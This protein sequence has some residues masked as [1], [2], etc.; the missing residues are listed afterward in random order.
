MG[1]FQNIFKVFVFYRNNFAV[2]EDNNKTLEQTDHLLTSIQSERIPNTKSPTPVEENMLNENTAPQITI[3]VENVEEMDPLHT[4]MHQSSFEQQGIPQMINKKLPFHCNICGKK[5]IRKS[6]LKAHMRSHT[7]ERP[8]ECLVCDYKFKYKHNL[9]THMVLHDDK[10]P[11]NCS[12]CNQKFNKMPFLD[13][14]MRI[15]AQ[16]KQLK[17]NNKGCQSLAPKTPMDI[18]TDEKPFECSECWVKCPTNA[19]LKLHSLIHTGERPFDCNICGKTF[20]RKFNLKTH[21]NVHT[22]VN[23]SR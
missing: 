20:N 11:F 9:I 7:N 1:Y 15:H 22:C 10:R 2:I 17:Y 8:F 21:M 13:R 19:A 16:E 18:H 23:A 3:K 5:F 14:H 6:N 4:L 12:V